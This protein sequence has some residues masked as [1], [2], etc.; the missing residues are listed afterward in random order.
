MDRFAETTFENNDDVTPVPPIMP[1]PRCGTEAPQDGDDLEAVNPL[2]PGAVPAGASDDHQAVNPLP[3][4]AVPAGA[5][6]DQ[7]AVN[8]LPPG[9]VP[10]FSDA[11]DVIAIPPILP[12]PKCGT[13]V[14]DGELEFTDVT[15]P[16]LCEIVPPAPDAE[17]C[18]TPV[19]TDSFFVDL[20][21]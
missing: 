2:P 19:P 18:G 1:L 12:A 17:H 4:G 21:A 20:V 6:D 13:D 16:P 14:P 7:Q 8:P 15:P 9:A 5:S 3:P 11:D 10:A